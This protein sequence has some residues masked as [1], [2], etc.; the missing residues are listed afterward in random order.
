MR[1]TTCPSGKIRWKARVA[2]KSGSDATTSELMA[3]SEPIREASHAPSGA[4]SANATSTIQR[5]ATMRRKTPSS[6]VGA[7]IASSR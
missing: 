6:L 2:S 5:I 3:P 7:A 1:S 4:R